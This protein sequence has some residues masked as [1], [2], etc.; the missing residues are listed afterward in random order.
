MAPRYLSQVARIVFLRQ[1]ATDDN[2]RSQLSASWWDQM[3]DLAHELFIQDSLSLL[4]G[5]VS[6]AASSMQRVM[7]LAWAGS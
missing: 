1:H 2:L 6:V 7:S 3:D 5:L 4:L